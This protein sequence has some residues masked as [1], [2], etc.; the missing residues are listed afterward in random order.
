MALVPIY[1]GKKVIGYRDEP[2]PVE[3]LWK[4]WKG[5]DYDNS[6]GVFVPE[7]SHVVMLNSGRMGRASGT[8]WDSVKKYRRAI[9][10]DMDVH[11]TV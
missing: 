3:P 5:D 4:D 6:D 7:K 1:E 2:E 11:K 8:G 10:S 9:P